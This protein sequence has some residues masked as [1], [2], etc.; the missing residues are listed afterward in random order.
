MTARL[1]VGIDVGGTFT[2][3]VAIDE[4]TRRIVARVK[5]PTTHDAADGVAAGIVAGLARLLADPAVDAT[6]IAFIAHSTTQATN[7]LL[8]G[9]VARVG[10]VGIAGRTGLLARRAI[11]VPP[12]ALGGR[13]SFAPCCL[14]VAPDDA[15]AGAR[16]VDA[17]L[18]GGAQALVASDAFGVDRPSRERAVVAYARERGALAT[19]GHEVATTYGLRARTRTATLNTAILPTMMRTAELTA[20]V[21]ARAGIRVPLAIMRS[22]GGVMDVR[23]VARRPILTMLSGPAAG[24]AGALLH[25]CVTDGIFVEVGGTSAD[26]SAIRRGVPQMRAAR[27]GGHRLLL[28]TLD[29]RTLPVA[30]GSLVRVDLARR[31]V[32]AVRAVG[33]RSAHIGGFR[34]ACFLPE[35]AFARERSAGVSRARARGRRPLRAD[36]DV[37]GESAW[38][39]AGGRVRLRAAG[40]R[41]GRLRRARSPARLHRRGA[42]ARDPGACDGD[43]PADDRGAADGVRVGSADDG[44]RRGRRRSGGA[45][46]VRRTR[47]RT[48]ASPRARRGGDLARRGRPRA[49]P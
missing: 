16:A 25:E 39:R 5:T 6:R 14:F 8:E 19:A 46:S 26:C 34:Y 32:E 3:V 47:A 13:A 49:R 30:G 42:R 41:R 11:A 48:R 27:L 38:A 36:A 4:R 45:R 7:A 33:P 12:T 9:D 40:R 21:V 31:G 18:A 24:I 37:R 22:D 1:R 17:L 35:A 23:E 15:R 28:R 10:I 44:A 43:S 2:D 29:A 20:G